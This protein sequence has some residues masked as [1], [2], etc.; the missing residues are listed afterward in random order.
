M[1]AVEPW[2]IA[3]TARSH[4]VHRDSVGAGHARDKS[5]FADNAGYDPSY[6]R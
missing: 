1:A 5:R 3:R 6:F 4:R 2:K